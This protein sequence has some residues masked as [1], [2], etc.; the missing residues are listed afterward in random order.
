MSDAKA[1]AELFHRR[2]MHQI[3]GNDPENKK[4]SIGTVRNDEIRKDG[5][6]MSAAGTD[7]P[8]YPDLVINGL[9]GDENEEISVIES[10]VGAVG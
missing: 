7:H 5:V 1:Q 4:E 8:G 10:I 2:M 6:C 3:L 9:T